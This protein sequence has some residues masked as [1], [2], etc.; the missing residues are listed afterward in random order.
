MMSNC[1]C[2]L[3]S[4]SSSPPAWAP[5]RVWWSHARQVGEFTWNIRLLDS[6]RRDDRDDRWFRSQKGAAR[7]LPTRRR[8]A[9]SDRMAVAAADRLGPL[10][11]APAVAG[12]L[13]ATEVPWPM[14]W[15]NVLAP[16]G[17]MLLSKQAT[18]HAR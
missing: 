16:L 10:R 11:L 7:R 2:R 14:R 4:E 5:A 9:L 18:L 6:V 15:R 1:P 3:P 8:L 17:K 12:S 13:S